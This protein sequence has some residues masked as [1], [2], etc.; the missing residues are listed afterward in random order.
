MT[1]NRP[2][3]ASLRGPG[4]LLAAFGVA[5]I[6]VAATQPLGIMRGTMLLVIALPVIARSLDA[7]GWADILAR[8]IAGPGPSQG[9]LLSSYATWLG[10]SA[11]LTLD[12]AAVVATPVGIAV[13][14]RW[15][16]VARL[17]VGVAILGSNVG[18]MLFP[19]SNL[20]NLLVV[21]GT[22]IAFTTYVAT[23]LPPQVLAAVAVGALLGLR[24]RRAGMLKAGDGG[25]EEDT[26]PVTA[27][28]GRG[29]DLSTLVAGASALVGAILAV[30]VG[31]AG[32]DVALVFVAVAAVCAALALASD[33]VRPATLVRSIPTSGIVVV[34]VAA[35]AREPMI[36][37]AARLPHPGG[38][39]P[40]IAE[41]AVIAAVGGLVAAAINNLPAAAFGSFWLV[42]ASPEAIIAFLLGVNVLN[43]VTPHGSLATILARGIATASG[44]HVPAELY[45][46]NAWRYAAAGTVAGL[47]A[48]ALAR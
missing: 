3:S 26:D 5:A 16:T 7:L 41:L 42:G 27:T 31:I 6:V 28:A 40:S 29:Y 12:V 22:G 17:Q 45:I 25:D 30:I 35:I 44:H 8:R 11:L 37:L 18:S 4:F 33:A 19:F 36:E 21:A 14:R 32:G 10:T 24:A 23:A 1:S 46:R 13:A 48:L 47:I 9:R 15:R 43:M 38:V 20:T 34:L 39:A 2:L